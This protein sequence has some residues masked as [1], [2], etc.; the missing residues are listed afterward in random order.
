MDS[1]FSTTWQAMASGA[2]QSSAPLVRAATPEP[3][4]HS[5]VPI[6][7]PII[8]RLGPRTESQFVFVSGTGAG[9]S[10]TS[11]AG[12]QPGS[13]GGGSEAAGTGSAVKGGDF[14]GGC[15]AGRGCARCVLSL[16]LQGT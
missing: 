13:V 14:G 4:T 12:R 5:P 9:M 16:T 1:V 2:T 15:F 8:T 6:D 10:P 11:Q 7:A 3:T